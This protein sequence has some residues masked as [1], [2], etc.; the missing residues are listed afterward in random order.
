MEVEC[1]LEELIEQ[2]NFAK[3]SMGVGVLRSQR[4]E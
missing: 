2:V 1:K 3:I 4:Y